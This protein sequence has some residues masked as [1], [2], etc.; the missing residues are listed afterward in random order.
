LKA[1]LSPDKELYQKSKRFALEA[2]ECFG[3][4][5]SQIPTQIHELGKQDMIRSLVTSMLSLHKSETEGPYRD[6]ILHVARIFLDFY[7]E[8]VVQTL[9][10]SNMMPMR[11]LQK[12]IECLFVLSRR[13]LRRTKISNEEMLSYNEVLT[14]FHG[15][16]KA[17]QSKISQSN[18]KNQ[19]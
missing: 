15:L 6:A 1:E 14:Q 2:Y 3:K 11:Q 19:A 5:P 9:N 12:A 8:D 13:D 10:Q 16:Q 7:A 4:I 17:L 18:L